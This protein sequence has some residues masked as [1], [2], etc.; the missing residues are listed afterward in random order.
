MAPS[1]L[2]I[3]VRSKIFSL[4]AEAPD[5]ELAGSTMLEEAKSRTKMTKM[6]LKVDTLKGL[7]DRS[8]GARS[9]GARS[10]GARS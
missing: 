4:A 8:R 2:S 7:M 5:Q 9:R 3:R 10:R 6:M 1:L